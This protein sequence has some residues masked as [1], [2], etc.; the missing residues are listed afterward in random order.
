M[1]DCRKEIVVDCHPLSLY[2]I[3][4]PL[5]CV[6]DYLSTEMEDGGEY[7]EVDYCQYSENVSLKVCKKRF[8][9][10]REYEKRMK[11]LKVAEAKKEERKVLEREKRRKQFE[12]LKKEFGDG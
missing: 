8:E 5:S 9:T 7:L 11:R 1:K 3:E 10:D 12:K 6:I 4:G 2:D